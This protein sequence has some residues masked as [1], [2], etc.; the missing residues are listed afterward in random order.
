MIRLPITIGEVRPYSPPVFRYMNNEFVDDFLKDGT[1]RLSSV[2][3]FR[4]YGDEQRFDFQEGKNLLINISKEGE[5]QT[6]VSNS[7]HGEKSYILSSSMSLENSLLSCFGC[8]SV[9]K[10]MNPLD[11]CVA[12]SKCIPGFISSSFGPCYY[13]PKKTFD[14]DLGYLDVA[15][16][17]KNKEKFQQMVLSKLGDNPLY[18]K[19]SEF[20]HQCEF[21][22]VWTTN[23]PTDDYIDIVAKDATRFCRKIEVEGFQLGNHSPKDPGPHDKIIKM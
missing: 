1:L 8:N 5:G 4:K 3:K 18:L 11:F 7:I 10:I 13:M 20:S 2:D 15:E 16:I 14:L 21:R 23:E 22:F 19:S 6:L 17:E 12:V 9:L